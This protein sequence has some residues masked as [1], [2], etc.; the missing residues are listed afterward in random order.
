MNSLIM[1]IPDICEK[2][3]LIRDICGDD[4]Q[5]LM[6]KTPS[7][8]SGVRGTNAAGCPNEFESR[9][10]RYREI[11]QRT[12]RRSILEM[13]GPASPI[14]TMTLSRATT[15]TNPFALS[16]G[17][18]A[19]CVHRNGSLSKL[20]IENI[21][22]MMYPRRSPSC[23]TSRPSDTYNF[24]Q[25]PFHLGICSMEDEAPDNQF[26]TSISLFALRRMFFNFLLWN[27][28]GLFLSISFPLLFLITGSVGVQWI[29]RMT[30][31]F[32]KKASGTEERN[33][34]G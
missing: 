10:F 21:I 24:Y 8:C 14:L 12:K 3:S 32:D 2:E 33:E 18:G 16:P 19:S 29:C 4:R 17:F 13:S 7:R 1:C 30:W 25:F 9:R 15:S 27:F 31:C 5:S 22:C 34:H 20:N 28:L 6:E 11:D 23:E 26:E